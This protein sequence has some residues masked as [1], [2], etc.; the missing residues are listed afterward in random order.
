M[1]MLFILRRL[2]NSE[3]FSVSPP[4]SSRKVSQSRGC[5][6]RTMGAGNR[7][8]GEQRCRRKVVQ[9]PSMVRM[10]ALFLKTT[11]LQCWFRISAGLRRL[12]GINLQRI[13]TG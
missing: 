13:S 11:D 10:G 2:F 5:S 3:G 9:A 1:G 8:P 12:L 4:N 7:A 6:A